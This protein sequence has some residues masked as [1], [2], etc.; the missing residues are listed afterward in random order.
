VALVSRVLMEVSCMSTMASESE[1]FGAKFP[2]PQ[3]KVGFE[4]ENEEKGKTTSP[5]GFSFPE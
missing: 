5:D 2:F 1:P 3:T 4:I